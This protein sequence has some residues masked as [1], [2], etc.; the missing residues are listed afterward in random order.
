MRL[1][2]DCP[3]FLKQFYTYIET[4]RGR[5]PKTADEYYRDLRVFFR[6]VLLHKKIVPDNLPFDEIPIGRMTLQI[7]SE[8][9]LSDVYDYM[10]FLSRERPA[11]AMDPDKGFGI[12]PAARARKVASLRTFFKYMTSTTHQLEENPVSNLEPPKL[13]KSLPRYLTLDESR[14]LLTSVVS[15]S[16][17]TKTRD[18]C[19]LTLF[20]NCGIRVSELCSINVSDRKDDTLVVTGKG[21]KQRV[22]YLNDACIAA[23]DAWME[24][25]KTKPGCDSPAL[26]PT[27]QSKRISAST[28]KWLVKKYLS[29][30]GLSPERYSAHKLR[31]TAA[32]LMYQNGVDVRIL[33]E[34][35]GHENLDTTRIYTH[36]DNQ[37]V[38]EAFRKNPLAEEKPDE[39][40]SNET[41]R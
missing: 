14:E 20:L 8:V 17:E 12:G 41:E 2:I 40:K 13:R 9:T 31:H 27:R 25:R 10:H 11:N 4:V 6:W 22:I 32:T 35:L 28:A 16:A 18:L 24:D 1:D 33:Q 37:S 5:S 30:A 3:D 21:N 19:I 38:R 26:F 39:T 29:A 34:V 7:L 15:V 36:V 23:W